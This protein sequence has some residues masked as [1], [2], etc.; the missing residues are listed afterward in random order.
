VGAAFA[1]LMLSCGTNA[2]KL[3]SK[4]NSPCPGNLPLFQEW[5][6]S[7]F[8]RSST[9]VFAVMAYPLLNGA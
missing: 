4:K 9:L 6:R 1:G 7:P 8:A 5:D 3:F 2:F